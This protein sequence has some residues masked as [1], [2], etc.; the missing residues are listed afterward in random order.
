MKYPTIL[1]LIPASIYLPCTQNL[2]SM[3][4]PVFRNLIFSITLLTLFTMNAGSQ[5]PVKNYEKEWKKVDDFVKKQLPKSAL[6]EVKNIYTLAKKDKQDAQIIKS[7]VYMTGLQMDTREDNE[8]FSIKEIEKEIATSKEP[9][10]SILT[11]LLADMY[12]NYYNDYRWQLYERTQTVNFKKDDIATWGTEDFHKKI[13]ELYLQSIKEEKLLQQTKLAPYDAIILKGNVRHLR[14]TLFDLLSHR[15]LS[16]FENDERDIKKPAYAFEIDQASAFDPAADFIHRKFPTKDS[17]SLQHKA[18]LIYQRLIAFHINDAKPDALIDADIQRIEFVKSKSVHSAKDELY[19]NSINH[20]ANQ[21][22]NTPAAAQAWYLVANY[23]E[24]KA[25]TYTPYGDTT[26]RY[27]RIKAKEICEKVLAQK[28]SSEGK[29]NCYNLLNQINS[30]S[31]QFSIEKVNIPGQPFRALVSYRNFNQLYLRIIKP[32]E[33]L[34]KELEN[35]YDEKYWPAVIAAKPVRS[36]E[37][38]LPATND[39]QKHS[40]E[41]KVDGLAAGEYLLIAST[42]KDFTGKKTILGARLFYV[43]TISYVNSNDDFFVLN[44]DNGQPLASA[45]VQVWQQKYDYK[46]SKYIREKLKLYKTDANGYFRMDKKTD[47]NYS[48]SYSLDITH[49]NEHLYL[50]DQPTYYYNNSVAMPPGTTEQ[51]VDARTFTYL[52]SDR[53]IYRPGQTVFF[54]GIVIVNDKENKSSVRSNY[55]TEVYLFDANHQK[56]DS[57]DVETNEY[58]SFAGKFQLPQGVL[59]GQFSIQMQSGRGAAAIQS[60]RIQAA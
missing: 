31:L 9:A 19:F 51:E 47:N 48:N 41:I 52:F 8:V 39:L 28:D 53:S 13:S 33:K 32:D 18:L 1:H 43:S 57:I 36:W 23:Y 40:A 4:R 5:Q 54:K 42:D 50:D 35:Q 26:Y 25:A 60:G 27:Q 55:K 12:L 49:N 16:Y 20:I 38:S 17:S 15:A 21:Y 45:A 46:V 24:Q 14:P 56:I 7:L 58:G 22:E 29:I 10:A 2:I 6:T 59:N 11:S 34:K 3:N 44:R 37:Q 30:R